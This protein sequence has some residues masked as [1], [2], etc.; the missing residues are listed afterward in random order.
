MTKEADY[1]KC[2][3]S[4]CKHNS[5]TILITEEEYVEEK[6]RYYHPDC[7]HEK[8]TIAE[9]IDFWYR[10]IDEDVV[11]N[12][13]VKI[14]NR[15]IYKECISCDYLLWALKKKESVINHPPGLVYISKDKQLKKEWEFEKKLKDFNESK[16][17]IE[18][19]AENEPSFIYCENGSKKKFGDIFGGK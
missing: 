17:S 18:I 16:A 13:L 7:K 3:Y 6:G 10:H 11:F 19:R 9:I 15:L 5:K 1:K 8:D 4:H 2:N 12:Q 14:I